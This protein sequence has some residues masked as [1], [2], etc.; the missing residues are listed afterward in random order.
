[1][2]GTPVSLQTQLVRGI[3]TTDAVGREER[4]GIDP[5]GRES[6][7]FGRAKGERNR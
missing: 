1:M 4:E 5:S 7:S 2:H 3:I 6:N